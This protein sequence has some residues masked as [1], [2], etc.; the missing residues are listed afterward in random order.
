MEKKFLTQEELTKI[1]DANTT[2]NKAKS[3]LG[4]LE[5]DKFEI[6]KQIEGLKREFSEMEMELIKKYGVNA[7]IN[8][9]TGEVT[10]KEE[11]Y[12]S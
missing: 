1:Q 4:N 6:L 2:F 3:A 9:Q 11:S 10:P 7:V 8:M 5:M 12:V